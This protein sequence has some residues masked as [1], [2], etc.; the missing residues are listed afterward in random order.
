[1]EQPR[2]LDRKFDSPKVTWSSFKAFGLLALLLAMFVSPETLAAGS[3]RFPVTQA[4]AQ[5]PATSSE[6]SKAESKVE[7]DIE[8]VRQQRIKKR[9]L[10][11]ALAGG[12]ILMLLAFGYGYLRLELTT[13]GFYS[14]RLQIAAGIASLSI[15]TAAYFLWRWMIN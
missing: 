10:T 7:P 13:R 1:M 15:I 12:V 2:L 4:D 6:D 11:V 5:E 8:T 14:G 3:N 9:L